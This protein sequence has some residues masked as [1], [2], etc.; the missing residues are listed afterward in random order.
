VIDLSRFFVRLRLNVG[1][2][3]P[4]FDEPELDTFKIPINKYVNK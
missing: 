1:S 4:V 3:V 2:P